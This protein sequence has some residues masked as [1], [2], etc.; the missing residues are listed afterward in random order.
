MKLNMPVTNDEQEMDGRETLVSKTD[1]KGQ[2]TYVNNAFIKISGFTENELIG[3]SHNIVRHP[4]M[5]V[6][7]F[8]DFWATLKDGRPWAGLVKNRCKNGDFYWVLANASPIRE[9]GRIVGYMSVRSKPTRAQIDQIAPIYQ[10]FKDGRQGDMRIEDGKVVKGKPSKLKFFFTNLTLKTRLVFVLAVMAMLLTGIGMVGLYGMS[11]SNEGLEVV[12]GTHTTALA[13]VSDIRGMLL[14]NRLA[15]AV[16]QVTSTPEFIAKQ[17]A[18][19][20]NNIAEITKIWETYTAM[21]WNPE[22][23]KL[24]D[25]FAADR[26]MFVTEGLKPAISALRANNLKEVERIVVEKIRP[27]YQP[28]G[29]DIEALNKAQLADAKKEHEL[30]KNRYE[31]IRNISIASILAGLALS[32]WASF[33]LIR[34]I[35]RPL[36]IAMQVTDAVAAGDLT[37]KIN[38]T[39]KIGRAHV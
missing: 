23:K 14:K 18:E 37:T 27:L 8:A 26:K 15:I 38:V 29:E 19:V 6:E 31:N 17:T 22:E 10:M 11:K 1:L 30:A 13:Y 25:K 28:V 33:L 9:G 32:V 24:N 3:K 16:A 36:N 2:I 20:E 7:A 35:I 21:D 4:D 12:Y 5:P 34:A 39:S